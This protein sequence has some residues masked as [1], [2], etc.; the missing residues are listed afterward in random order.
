MLNISRSTAQFVLLALVLILT[1]VAAALIWLAAT[2]V[3]L[4]GATAV[5]WG[6]ALL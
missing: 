2:V 6:T 3:P 1:V 5:V 4:G